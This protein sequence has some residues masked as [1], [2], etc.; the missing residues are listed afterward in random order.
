MVSH[1]N[2]YVIGAT[3]AGVTN[4]INIV[5]IHDFNNPIVIV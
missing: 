3:V 5:T 1:V 4:A 2:L